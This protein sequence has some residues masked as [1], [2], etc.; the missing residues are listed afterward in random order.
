MKKVLMIL[1]VT[2]LFA[3]CQDDFGDTNVDTKK[4]P[5]VPPAALFVASQK[6]LVDEITSSN[7]N[8]NIFRLISQYWTETTYFDEA[9]Y[10]LT[11]R[12]I[13]QNFWNTL[14]TGVLKNL[15]EAQK[16]I[17]G[18]DAAFVSAAQKKNQNAC[19]EILN[20][21][22]YSV[23]VNTFG[24]VPYSDALNSDNVFPKYDDAAAIYDDLFVRLDKALADIDLNSDGFASSDLFY[25]GDMSGWKTFGN[26]LKLR[27]GMIIADVN[28]AKAK[29][30]VEA[31][32]PNA[33]SSNAENVAFH[34]LSSPP[35]TNPIWVDLVQ[36]GRKDFVATHTIVDTMLY[37]NDPR[38]DDYFTLDNVSGYSGGIPG[39]GNGYSEYSKPSTRI[40]A[41][42]FEALLIDYSEVEFLRAEAVERGMSVG[43]TAT[44][45]YNNAVTAS[46]EYWGGSMTEADTYLAQPDVAYATAPGDYKAKIGLQKWLA[47]Y[48]RGF[49]AW[50]ELRRLDNP[51]LP[52]PS[53]PNSGFPLRLTYPVQEQTL[54]ADNYARGASSIGGDVVETKLFWDKF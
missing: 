6:S 32:S 2:T 9:N 8:Q 11:T 24:N 34:Y 12:N 51:Q 40:T 1:F 18:Q 26:S 28:P 37:L 3:A 29:T 20:V 54:N 38:T 47:L 4:P 50:V 44:E 42:D 43:G 22:T 46:I 19:I 7:V 52:A 30:I 16:L 21:Y 25:G 36:S 23:L 15:N 10:D 48:N 17:P 14:Y 31:A 13:P 33:I 27:L 49:D 35:N 53:D 45:H 39:E 5:V 41:P